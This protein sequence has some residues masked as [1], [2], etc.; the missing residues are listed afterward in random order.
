M[1]RAKLKETLKTYLVNILNSLSK[2]KLA[3]YNPYI[4]A[5]TGNV[6]KTTTKDYIHT[7]LKEGGIS[8]R[9]T[10]K[11][12][13]S[14]IGLPLTILGENNP[15]DSFWGWVKIIF[16]HSVLNF[17]IEEYPKV[18]VLEAGAD[19]PLDIWKITQ[20]IT[21]KTVVL[22]AFAGNPVHA[23]FFPNRETHLREKKYLLDALP[24]NGLLIYNSDDKDMSGLADSHS[25]QK[26]ISYGKASPDIKLLTTQ[27]DYDEEEKPTGL[28]VLFVMDNTQHE[29][30]LKGVLG[31]S[32]AYAVLAAVATG[33]S[34]NISLE[35]IIDSFTRVVLPKSRLRLLEGK[36]NSILIDDTYNSSP[37]ATQ[38]ALE[39]LKQVATQGKKILILGHM[40]E[41]GSVGEAEH[42]KVGR[43]AA[44]VADAVVLVGRHN[45]RYLNGL[46]EVKFNVE[47]IYLA[48]DS[49]EAIELIRKNISIHAGDVFL[50]KGSQSARIEKVT[51]S[52]LSNPK[53][54]RHVCRQEK[55]WQKR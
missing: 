21:P 33:L 49:E 9:A 45:D 2:K 35:K 3:K 5:I 41:L 10:Q 16:K 46:R 36:N 8:V 43:L 6:G 4:V 20:I 13:N 12:F 29:I 26:R 54:R 25:T 14:E 38:L 23:E 44:E 24:K 53:D 51:V 40:A 39:S 17:F 18:L 42:E 47:Q 30:Y 52:L 37:K 34:F 11:S 15:W 27:V 22:T 31:A 1:N 19:A 55:E 7:V 50:L 48:K 28:K 32:H